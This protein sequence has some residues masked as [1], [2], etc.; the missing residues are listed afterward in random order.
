[1]D[2][3]REAIYVSKRLSGTEEIVRDALEKLITSYNRSQYDSSATA[4]TLEGDSGL[5]HQVTTQLMKEL[6]HNA[7]QE[8]SLQRRRFGNGKPTGLEG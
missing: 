4:S 2:V 5:V 7:N 6:L 8:L 3:V 1:M